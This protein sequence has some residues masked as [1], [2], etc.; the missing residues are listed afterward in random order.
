MH[1]RSLVIAMGV[2][3]LAG[4]ADALSEAGSPA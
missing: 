3:A 2:L 4:C 1:I